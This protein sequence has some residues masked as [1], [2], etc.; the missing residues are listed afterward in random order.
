MRH[1]FHRLSQKRHLAVVGLFLT[2]SSQLAEVTV[3]NAMA[4]TTYTPFVIN[5]RNIATLR[6]DIESEL[7]RGIRIDALT[8]EPLEWPTNGEKEHEPSYVKPEFINFLK[9]NGIRPTIY[10]NGA[11]AQ[12]SD[13]KWPTYRSKDGAEPYG[14]N[15]DQI[16]ATMP[17]IARDR[18]GNAL[19]DPDWRGEYV[20][21]LNSKKTDP[22]GRTYLDVM[23]ETLK[24]GMKRGVTEF[25]FDN[26][27]VAAYRKSAID[28]Y[29]G[30][31]KAEKATF[32]F[33]KNL[34]Q[35]AVAMAK[36][37][38]LKEPVK[39]Y[40]QNIEEL[41]TKKIDDVTLHVRKEY[42]GVMDG[43]VVENLRFTGDGQAGGLEGD[44]PNWEGS[45][46]GK[47]RIA[48]L[49]KLKAAGVD[50]RMVDYAQAPKNRLDA[51]KF[52]E[53]HGFS[54][55]VGLESHKQYIPLTDKEAKIFEPLVANAAPVRPA[56]AVAQA[57]PAKPNLVEKAA[58]T[59]IA[60][61]AAAEPAITSGNIRDRIAAS[62][63][64][65]AKR[66]QDIREAN[67]KAAKDVAAAAPVAT[68]AAPAAAP[69]KPAAVTAPAP[70][71][72]E[73]VR[74]HTMSG[75][76]SGQPAAAKQAAATTANAVFTAAMEKF[77]TEITQINE[78]I[79]GLNNHDIKDDAAHLQTLTTIS[80]SALNKT[81]QT[82]AE[83]DYLKKAP[84]QALMSELKKT[85]PAIVK[86]LRE[87]PLTSAALEQ[88][89]TALAKAIEPHLAE[90]GVHRAQAVATAP[91][92]S[93][94]LKAAKDQLAQDLTSIRKAIGGVTNGNAKDD[95]GHLKTLDRTVK[96]LAKEGELKAAELDDGHI[97]IKKSIGGNTVLKSQQAGQL[98]SGFE[99]AS[100]HEAG[101]DFE[102]AI[103]QAASLEEL[104]RLKK[105]IAKAVDDNLDESGIR[106]SK[107][108]SKKQQQR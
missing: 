27:G 107:P 36:E 65:S 108:A 83:G 66:E 104:K 31:E 14:V 39:F 61:A 53:E 35:E 10:I 29:G 50:I 7:K 76:T 101:G 42:L 30:K 63:A 55:Y 78:A 103:R 106:G 98:K 96:K 13:H 94:P 93:D 11:Q 91:S 44:T 56:P 87:P 16:R 97:G 70:A 73:P 33:I 60:S 54:T 8:F 67:I 74:E 32:D 99:E 68:P 79:E 59:V 46:G 4:Q 38:G 19:E 89:R 28:Y 1:L 51:M 6:A 9:E 72:A 58:G 23:K 40:A 57:V 20:I 22:Q 62:M 43:V 2:I 86:S 92:A 100:K 90:E 75:L 25:S 12:N 48:A 84:S 41:M 105:D 34:K 82:F 47:W 64:A 95:A 49:D 85:I 71:V 15:S 80:A 88:A 3:S 69:A 17:W 77:Q 21:D 26:F 81:P 102:A 45:N 52:A 18:G 24:E 5:S 37:M